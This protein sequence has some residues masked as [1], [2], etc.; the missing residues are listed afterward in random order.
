MTGWESELTSLP[1]V[2]PLSATSFPI[3]HYSYV[4]P[5]SKALSLSDSWSPHPLSLF[6]KMLVSKWECGQG[7]CLV[8]S[9]KFSGSPFSRTTMACGTVPLDT[10]SCVPWVSPLAKVLQI[11]FLIMTTTLSSISYHPHFLDEEMKPK[12]IRKLGTSSKAT[13]L[14]APSDPLGRVTCSSLG[15]LSTRLA[16][17]HKSS[18]MIAWPLSPRPSILS[19]CTR[20]DAALCSN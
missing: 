11:T 13:S 5:L 1:W 12:V 19:I 14:V 17:L 15:D 20:R 4:T 2:S 3:A 9:H 8:W 6:T 10:Y 7:R 16:S 18:G